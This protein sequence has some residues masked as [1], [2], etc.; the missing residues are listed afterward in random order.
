MNTGATG[1]GDLIE[2]VFNRLDASRADGW[3]IGGDLE[4]EIDL[5]QS[6]PGGLW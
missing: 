1:I 5:F 2:V 3:T 6:D 4:L